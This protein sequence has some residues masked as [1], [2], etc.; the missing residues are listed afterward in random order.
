[1]N[2][3]I[4]TVEKLRIL[5]TSDV[6]MHLLSY[7]Y[8]LQKQTPGLGLSA[9]T[10][11]IANLR[12]EAASE[13]PPRNSILVDNGDLLHG[14]PL[15]SFLAG[16]A[17]AQGPHPVAKAMN[18]LGYAAMGVGNHDLEYGLDYLG[19]FA[20]SLTAPLISSNLK[21]SHPQSWLHPYQ[22]LYC[23]RI[24][25]GVVSVLP[26]RTES[27]TFAN[28]G[29][30]IAISDMVQSVRCAAEQAREKGA[31]IVIALAHTGIGVDKQE[32]ALQD[33]AQDG[34]IDALVGGHTHLSFPG[35]DHMSEPGS[36]MASGTLHS[37]PTVMPGFGGSHVGCIDLDLYPS[38][39]TERRI[40]NSRAELFPA[41]TSD[42]ICAP[43]FS[44][45]KAPHERTCAQ[46][47]EIIGHS[48]VPLTSHFARL[49][50]TVL[51]SL[52]A[53]AQTAAL[54]DI[55]KSSAFSDLPL[56]SAVSPA[57][58][59]GRA[60]PWNYTDIPA[61][62]L[63]QRHVAEMDTFSN[64]IWAVQING[65]ELLE[66]L[67]KSASVF[68]HQNQSAEQRLID[69]TFPSFDFD[70]IHGLTYAIDPTQPARF[71]THG[72]CI[73]PQAQRVSD[74]R[75]NG[76]A[77]APSDQFLVAA[78]NYRACGGGGFAGL[79]PQRPVLRPLITAAE[80]LLA[81]MRSDQK[82]TLQNTWRFAPA[83]QG[84]KCWLQTGPGALAHMADIEHFAPKP[85]LSQSSGFVRI[86]LTL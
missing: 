73:N 16:D 35:P 24:K 36:N 9:L 51:L 58:S 68:V 84:Q 3:Q 22:I 44:A 20:S 50:P 70:V 59:G 12:Q 32:N 7:D 46:L 2:T 37:I 63:R 23:G 60:G 43:V 80:A 54:Q 19:A 4:Q 78:N 79:S 25:V 52:M 34:A 40:C 71:D 11:T 5:A 21:L 85:P 14:T 30:K 77:V 75:R 49:R 42:Q 72:Q 38:P 15:A 1:M 26:P 82:P 76:R 17:A 69:P 83:A 8:F 64:V 31:D 28:L 45:L 81:Y 6:H 61:G 13:S 10:D 27:W 66:W 65:A 18:A 33:I 39:S 41:H 29:G 48:E 47:D 56:L 74:V 67:E 55:Q 57:R 86:S 53:A 62:P